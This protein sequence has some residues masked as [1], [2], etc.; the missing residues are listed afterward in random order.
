MVTIQSA[1]IY[2]TKGEM[3]YQIDYS[4]GVSVR[5]VESADRFIRKEWKTPAGW[6]QVGKPYKVAHNRKRNAEGLKA[7]AIEWVRA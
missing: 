7:I 3:A 2:S 5:A 4:N 6:A 1:Q